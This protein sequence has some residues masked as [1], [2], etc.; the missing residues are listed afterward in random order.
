M[1]KRKIHPRT[2]H[3]ATALR[4]AEKEYTR[5]LAERAK[6][7]SVLAQLNLE[8][9]NL[10]QMIRVLKNNINPAPVI[11]IGSA[12]L[13]PPH[14]PGEV[15]EGVGSIAVNADASAPAPQQQA[16]DIDSI[17]GMTEEGWT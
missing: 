1:P 2:N 17:P 8:I 10:E 6:A 4:H 11:P 13:L 3:F 5:K 14:E 9:P 7:V 16:P 15:P 12:L